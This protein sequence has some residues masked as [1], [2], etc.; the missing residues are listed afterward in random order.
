M[1]DRAEIEADALRTFYASVGDLD[2]ESIDCLR[3]ER[4]AALAKIQRLL[5]GH[6]QYLPPGVD[7]DCCSGCNRLANGYVRWP[8]PLR[9]ALAGPEDRNEP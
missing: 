1:T 3:T 5:E 6:D 8:C 2:D 9:A 7:Y 4:D